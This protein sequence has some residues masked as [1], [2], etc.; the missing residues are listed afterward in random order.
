MARYR[1]LSTYSSETPAELRKRLR[2]EAAELRADAIA[3]LATDDGW[4]AFVEARVRFAYS[5]RNCALVAHQWPGAILLAT[6]SGWARMG[7]QVNEG[8]R[9]R[10]AITAPSPKG[11]FRTLGL[12]EVTQ[13]SYLL[14]EDPAGDD[15]DQVVDELLERFPTPAFTNQAERAAELD[16]AWK[17]MQS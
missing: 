11:G 5:W 7:Y 8:E 13:T 16:A 1:P 9:C 10:V 3:K 15:V 12:F 14:G 6:Y 4:Q 17:G 2:E